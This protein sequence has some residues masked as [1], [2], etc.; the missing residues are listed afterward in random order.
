M[1][2]ISFEIREI[3]YEK[4]FESLISQLT[5]ECRSKTDPTEI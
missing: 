3:N 5:E 2:K 4:S 1:I